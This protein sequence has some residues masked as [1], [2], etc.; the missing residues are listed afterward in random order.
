MERSFI[1]TY[2]DELKLTMQSIRI[3]TQAMFRGKQPFR[4][5]PMS[6]EEAVAQYMLLDPEVKE[7]FR[8]QSPEASDRLEDDMLRKME[9]FRN[10]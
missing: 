10:E 5:E 6:D 1:D 9:S 8:T 4:K 2:V 7:R 3:E